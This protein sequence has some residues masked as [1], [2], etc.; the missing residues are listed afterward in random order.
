M[1][2][3]ECPCSSCAERRRR[4]ED[5]VSQ[6][7]ARCPGCRVGQPYDGHCHTETGDLYSIMCE[8]K[9]LRLQIEQGFA[10]GSMLRRHDSVCDCRLCSQAG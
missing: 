2:G 1:H 9:D 8:A 7:Q 5:A 10:E 4:H 3:D 6:M